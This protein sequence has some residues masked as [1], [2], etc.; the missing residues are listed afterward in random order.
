MTTP[1]RRFHVT[2]GGSSAVSLALALILVVP[3][4]CAAQASTQRTQKQ[5]RPGQAV[6]QE[7]EAQPPAA[8]EQPSASL[9]RRRAQQP[10]AV[11][12]ERAGTTAT[13]V[14]VVT[15]R[16]GIST[17]IVRGARRAGIPIIMPIGTG[18]VPPPAS[19]IR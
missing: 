16:E 12:P 17:T 8:L 15:D 19:P 3:A 6:G 4:V 18:P 9:A 14:A 11:A 7:L 5:R 1:S 13:P 10:P 2:F